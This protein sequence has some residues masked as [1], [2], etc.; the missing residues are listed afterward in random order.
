MLMPENKK[1]FKAKSAASNKEGHSVIIKRTI[2]QKDITVIN[3][4]T[5]N[6]RALKC[7]K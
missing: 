5:T 7:M 4:H 6:N 1:D 2:H 3:V